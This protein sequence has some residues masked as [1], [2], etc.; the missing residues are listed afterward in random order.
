MS[1]T[2]WSVC[3]IFSKRA[4]LIRAEVEKNGH[5]TFQPTFA[6]VWMSEG[7]RSARERA[8]I[9][10]YLFFMTP[11]EGWGSVG[12][13]EG[14]IRVLGHAGR[15]SKVSDEEMYRLVVD[16]ASGAHN[17]ISAPIAAEARTR[18]RRKPRPSKRARMR[19]A[20]RRAEVVAA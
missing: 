13:T 18:R 7:K 19:A 9:P 5:G 2:H 10:G 4:H 17:E 12:A 6:R 11:P 15:A 16:H 3:Q 1:G 20:S 14:V 8:L